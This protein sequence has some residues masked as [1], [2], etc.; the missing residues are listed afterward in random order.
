MVLF[1]LAFILLI[2]LCI[3]TMKCLRVTGL[4]M[5]VIVIFIFT[6]IEQSN[7]FNND[8]VDYIGLFVLAIS[9]SAAVLI[10]IKN[11]IKIFIPDFKYRK[12]GMLGRN[13]ENFNSKIS[14]DREGNLI[15]PNGQTV[16]DRTD[17]ILGENNE[18]I[19]NDKSEDIIEQFLKLSELKNEK[20]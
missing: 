5:P 8:I 14:W 1:I 17:D 12:V 11:I 13:K 10:L 20:I 19:E 6:K 15:L 16:K 3:L 2:M 18:I 7:K 4:I 9:I